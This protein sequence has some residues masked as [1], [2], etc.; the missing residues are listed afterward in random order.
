MT[1]GARDFHQFG[2]LGV[3]GGTWSQ[4]L[5]AVPSGAL[6]LRA[7]SSCQA[8]YRALVHLTGIDLPVTDRMRVSASEP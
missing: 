5:R 1:S 6:R 3:P 8:R 4:R 2:A 7:G